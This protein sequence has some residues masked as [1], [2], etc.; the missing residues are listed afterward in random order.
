V[1]NEYTFG[2]QFL[3]ERHYYDPPRRFKRKL[4]YEARGRVREGHEIILPITVDY[5]NDPANKLPGVR[6]ISGFS[7][8]RPGE[9]GTEMWPGQA[10]FSRH[11]YTGLNPAGEFS[12]NGGLLC[13]GNDRNETS[14]PLNALGLA[15]GTPDKKDWHT[16]VPG[17]FLVPVLRLACPESSF[18][19]YK[20]EFIVRDVQ[21]FPGPWSHHHRFSHPGTGRPAEVWQTEFNCWRKPGAERLM[22]DTDISRDDPRFIDLLHHVGAKLLLRSYVFQAHKGIKTVQVYAAHADDMGFGVF[23][24]P[25]MEALKANDN[26]LTEALRADPG[27]QL[28]VVR[29]VVALMRQSVPL[30]WTR[31]GL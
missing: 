13:P 6:V 3:E 29:R 2:S 15:D 12:G 27:P 17:T 14:G 7:N 19:G 30:D 18:F 4:R 16:V 22:S 8:Q 25:W 10:G 31:P 20:T 9:N 11:Y 23:P 28:S 26:E 21:P 5:V 1:W 24:S